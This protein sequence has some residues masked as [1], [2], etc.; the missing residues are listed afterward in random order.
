MA[1]ATEQ[2]AEV[3]GVIRS[4]TIEIATKKL[5]V[6]VEKEGIEKIII[7]ISEGKMAEETSEFGKM[8]V[9]KLKVPVVFQDETL[10]TY[11]AQDLSIKAGIKGKKRREMEDAFAATL[12][13]QDYLDSQDTR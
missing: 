10:T 1:T 2:L 5:K 9:E 4:E 11:E 7:G 6:I 3:Y 12:I 13:L 8:L